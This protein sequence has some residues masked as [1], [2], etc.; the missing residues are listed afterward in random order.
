[1]NITRKTRRAFSTV[2][3]LVA[4]GLI[5]IL[6]VVAV[7]R[8]LDSRS[9]VSDSSAKQQLNT[10][11]LS[12]NNWFAERDTYAGLETVVSGKTQLQTRVPNVE[13]VGDAG[14]GK[15]TEGRALKVSFWP[16]GSGASVT[17]VTLA[18]S[19]GDMNCWYIR[20]DSS[21]TK[22]GYSNVAPSSCKATTWGT[23]TG[24]KEGSFE[25]P[26]PVA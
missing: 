24:W 3:I 23:A 11:M 21:G 20:L 2:E 15:G 22:Y 10:V 25:F 17:G 5:A 26:A 7:P 13:I 14:T 19:N 1:M 8:L 6:M 12:V 18:A 4:V 9:T 16:I